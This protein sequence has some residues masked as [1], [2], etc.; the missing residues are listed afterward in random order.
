MR[1]TCLETW[2]KNHPGMET[3]EKSNY[4]NEKFI[5]YWGILES[6]RKKKRKREREKKKKNQ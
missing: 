2:M 3:K 1:K 6:E 5:H 4:R